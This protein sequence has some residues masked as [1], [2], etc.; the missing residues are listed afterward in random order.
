MKTEEK[1][2]HAGKGDIHYWITCDRDDPTREWMVF[3][4]GL[5]AEHHLFDAQIE[6]FSNQYNCLTWD[7]PAHGESR[8]YPLDF[9]ME[10]VTYLLKDVISCEEIKMP[11]MVGQSYGGYLIQM[12]T[13][14]F[15]KS[16]R[17]FVSIDSCSIR[18]KHTPSWVTA[19]LKHTEWMYR[20]IPWKL[21]VSWSLS[22]AT[23]EAGKQNYKEAIMKYEK[24]EFCKLAGRGFASVA[25]AIELDRDYEPDC[26][27]LLFCGTKDVAGVTKKL[28]QTWSKAEGY[29]LVWVEG[30]GHNSNIDSP[31][32]VN[33]FIEDF[34]NHVQGIE[35]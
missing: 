18:K 19:S 22:I 35:E 2:L 4:P 1:I 13:S 12:Y 31:E 25:E 10:E 32:F 33:S 28:N 14:L 6:Y 11:I 20:M 8:P 34:I 27:V 9:T 5:T 7:A 16:M 30:A 26:P 15:P 21:L 29:R 17:A 23:S 24:K 3:L